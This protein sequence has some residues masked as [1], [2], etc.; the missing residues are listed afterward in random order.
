MKSLLLFFGF[1][2]CI[3]F[4]L[5]YTFWMAYVATLRSE[6]QL[7]KYVTQKID[8]FPPPNI[9]LCHLFVFDSLPLVIPQKVTNSEVKIRRNLM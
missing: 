6:E 9:T 8:I 5:D 7:K 4:D 3:A 2:T 1:I